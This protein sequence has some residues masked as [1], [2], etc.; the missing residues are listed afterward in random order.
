[1]D[2]VCTSSR[3]RLLQAIEGR[4]QPE[5]RDFAGEFSCGNDKAK[6]LRESED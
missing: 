6:I 1:M 4:E 3:V 5:L 2:K